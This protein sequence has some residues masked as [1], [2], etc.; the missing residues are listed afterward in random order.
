MLFVLQFGWIAVGVGV[1]ILLVNLAGP[2]E[3][4]WGRLP[5]SVVTAVGDVATARPPRAVAVGILLVA[6][7]QIT[8]TRVL[9]GAYRTTLG[10]HAG[11]IGLL[12]GWLGLVWIGWAR[13]PLL[14]HT[15]R[16]IVVR[17]LP[18]SAEPTFLTQ[19]EGVVSYYGVSTVGLA[20]VAVCVA[21]AATVVVALA[22]GMALGVV[23]TSGV[24][25]ALASAG[26]F[27]AGAFG[28][29]I[30]AGRPVS[31]AGIVVGVLVWDLGTYGVELGREVGRRA[32]SRNA[33]VVH[34]AGTLLVS[35]TAAGAAVLATDLVSRVPL[36]PDAPGPLALAAG[37]AAVV[38][39]VLAVRE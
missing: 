9:R 26:V 36:S 8:L 29:A 19:W 27:G 17:S 28:V 38:V 22:L 24:G 1:V 10:A 6:A 13:A 31:L 5:P 7:A 30:G 3:T 18:A 23:P 39:F 12:A 34:A 4:V 21:V 15:F 11:K 16:L 35:V 20:M 14:T 37:L 33:Q 25:H 32:P 2:A